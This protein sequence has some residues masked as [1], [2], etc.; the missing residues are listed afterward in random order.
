MNLA[1]TGP[2]I[3]IGVL[4]D[5]FKGDMARSK[6]VPISALRVGVVLDSPIHDSDGNK[7]LGAGVEVINK[8]LERLRERGI[9][10]VV[11]PMAT[12]SLVVASKSFWH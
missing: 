7:L 8:V 5:F 12:S 2:P 4:C 11:T 3:S 10:V 1:K 9:R 6:S